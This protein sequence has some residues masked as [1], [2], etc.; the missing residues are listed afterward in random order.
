MDAGP[1]PHEWMLVSI[2]GFFVS[3]FLIHDMSLTWGL[4]FD[5]VFLIMFISSIISMSR[6]S[7]EPDHLEELAVHKKSVRAGHHRKKKK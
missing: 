6:D 4:L 7:L 1:L 3:V 5:I 2:I